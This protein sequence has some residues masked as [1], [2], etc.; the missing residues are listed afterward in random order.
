MSVVMSAVLLSQE[1][2]AQKPVGAVPVDSSISPA[3]D[4]AH[5]DSVLQRTR[6]ARCWRA[7]PM[8]ECRMVFL[9]DFGLD[10]PL[11]TTTSKDPAAR[12]YDRA[13]DLRMNWS[14]GL[15][16]NGDRHSHGVSF[17][18]TS[19]AGFTF[20]MIAEYRYR[21]WRNHF[22][23][24]AGAGLKRHGVWVDNVGLVKGSGL[25]TMLGISPSRWFGTSLR[26]ET[27][28]VRGQRFSGVMLGV[29]STRVSEY[30]FQFLAIGIRDWLLG[31]IGIEWES[32]PEEQP[33]SD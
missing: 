25:T 33:P 31:L 16:R 14:I 15:M 26:Y 28:K 20:P 10:G 13:F 21:Q 7:R 8:P 19:E 11:H 6:H 9:T 17:S 32:E 4:S 12:Y 23:I 18:I 29:Q 22:A 1:P 24:D 2:V 27:M 3:A 30:A 5:L